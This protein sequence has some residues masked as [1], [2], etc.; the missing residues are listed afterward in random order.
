MTAGHQVS[1]GSVLPM[2]DTSSCVA[3]KWGVAVS[4][5]GPGAARTHVHTHTHTYTHT[6]IHTYALGGE[7]EG[8]K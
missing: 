5:E 1:I 2:A 8:V 7:E 3:L 6:H 4:G